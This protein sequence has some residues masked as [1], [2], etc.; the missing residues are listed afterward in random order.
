MWTRFVLPSPPFLVH[1]VVLI[2]G[3]LPIFL[4]G[5]EIKSGSGLGTRLISWSGHSEHINVLI[6]C[7]GVNSDS[8]GG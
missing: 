6:C 7:Q 3:L 8:D 1:D 2:L 4:H 5:Y